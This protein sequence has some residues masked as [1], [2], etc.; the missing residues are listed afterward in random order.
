MN[1]TDMIFISYGHDDPYETIVKKLASDLKDEGFKVWI[2]YTSVRGTKDWEKEIEQGITESSTVIVFM[3]DR[4]MRRPDGYCLDEICF[5]R[6]YNK[7]IMPIKIQ[8]VP[9]L[10]SIARIQWI[11][12]SKYLNADKSINEELYKRQKKEII[13]ILRGEKELPYSDEQY[14][15]MNTL[16]PLDNESYIIP[17]KCFYGR[18]WLFETF[19]KWLNSEND[20]RV[21]C[22]IGQ[23]GSGKTSFVSKLCET[24]KSVAA[25]HFCRYN[26]NERANPKNAITSLAYHLSTQLPEY[27]T[28]LLQLNDLESLKEKDVNRLFEYLFIEPLLKIQPPDDKIVVI[29]DALD[30]ATKNEATKNNKNDLVD[31]I[32]SDFKKL[33][34]WLKFVVT[35][36][37]EVDIERKLCCLNPFIIDNSSKENLDDIR[38]FLTTNLEPYLEG[39][40]NSKD[41][42]E[43]IVQKS[44]GVFLYASEI[45][46]SIE[47]G[48]LCVENAL[49]FPDG[50][51]NI[52]RTY[53]DRIFEQNTKFDYARDIRPLMEIVTVSIE[54]LDE[55][56][57][58]DILKIDDYDDYYDRFEDIKEYIHVLFPSKD[59]H[60]EPIHKSLNDWLIDRD[61]SGKY[62]VKVNLAN[63]HLSEYF[64][65]IYNDGKPNSYIAK[66]LA[67]HLIRAND[68]ALATAVLKD[69][70]L[71]EQKIE[72]Q[73]QD[74]GIRE[75][76]SELHEL[77]VI[78][79]ESVLDILLSN[80]FINLF[81]NNRRYLYNSGLFFDLKELGFDEI[82]SSYKKL[83]MEVLVGCVNYLYIT[84][85]YDQC[86][87]LAQSF[88]QKSRDNPSELFAHLFNKKPFSKKYDALMSEVENEIA[89]SCRKLVRFDD[90][91]EHCEAVFYFGRDNTDYYEIALAHQTIGKIF[92]HRGQ[93]TA[94]YAELCEAVRLLEDSLNLTTDADYIKMLKLYV[95]AFEREV[96]L[97]MVW[98]NDVPL[99]KKHLAHAGAIYDEL[100]SIDRYHI[101]YLYVDMFAETVNGNYAFATDLYPSLLKEAVS[102]Y[103]KSQI[104]FYYA[105]SLYLND[106]LEQAA[107][108]VDDALRFVSLIN[109]PIE[110][111][112]IHVLK[113]FISGTPLDII[114]TSTAKIDNGDI[115]SWTNFVCDFISDLKEKQKN[116]L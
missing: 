83:D 63:K 103:D 113:E 104:E 96:A 111:S 75:Y 40:T 105:L 10:L 95:A 106:N 81:R 114:K 72:L 79:H 54:P 23:A 59:G 55:D 17:M 91:L 85:K 7:T 4:S 60:I 9:P 42:I 20:S 6:R 64:Y 37:P 110:L 52:Y 56:I 99:A 2:D 67:K 27:K 43:T 98:K 92:Y 73:G 116:E 39:V 24:H 30:E 1:G 108:H 38:G 15:L 45:L 44:Q 87:Q 21:F 74:S 78:S 77:N 33:P 109:A 89:L 28:Q 14:H 12:M 61:L 58:K 94:A 65:K 34:N 46:K 19:E 80:T 93:W 112:V 47:S 100:K 35:T 57:I 22:I 36:R 115:K 16:K 88:K 76:L 11:D 97:S 102:N 101:R 5:A 18:E 53:F 107:K 13:S 31:L 69:G 32:V 86:E 29:I 8:D 62:Q 3:T 70:E 25:I 71:L 26:N 50:L 82:L 66:H 90:A 41:L 51:S 68:I 48:T 84:E 49:T